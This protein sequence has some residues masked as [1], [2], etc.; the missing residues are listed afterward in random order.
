METSP[1]VVAGG[2]SIV[3][4]VFSAVIAVLAL[5]AFAFTIWMLIDAIKRVPSEGNTKLIWILVIIF[6]GAIGSLIYFFVQ[7]PKN[8]PQT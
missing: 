5:A 2:M 8:P 4:C 6:A 3:V 7:R 1:D